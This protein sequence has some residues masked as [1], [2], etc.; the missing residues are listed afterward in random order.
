MIRHLSSPQNH[1]LN[2]KYSSDKFY[3]MGFKFALDIRYMK[4]TKCLLAI[5]KSCL[6]IHSATR[7]C[8]E[9]A[10]YSKCMT[11]LL[12]HIYNFILTLS[13]CKVYFNCNYNTFHI[14]TSIFSFRGEQH[15]VNFI[16][17]QH[18]RNRQR[19]IV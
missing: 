14:N 9:H 15:V 2:G 12:L 1:L 4:A 5:P 16:K 17:I 13:L 3:F 18:M 10:L 11:V 8:C 7:F 6:F 19:V